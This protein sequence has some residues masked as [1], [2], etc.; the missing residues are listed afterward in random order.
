MQ[1]FNSHIYGN[2]LGVKI[3][4]KINI[5]NLFLLYLINKNDLTIIGQK[6]SFNIMFFLNLKQ[7]MLN[8]IQSRL[9]PNTWSIASSYENLLSD[10]Y[11]L[12]YI[13][14]EKYSSELDTTCGTLVKFSWFV[15]FLYQIC[16][17]NIYSKIYRQ[18]VQTHCT[19]INDRFLYIV[20]I[21]NLYF[22]VFT[23]YFFVPDLY[24]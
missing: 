1:N 13:L 21:Y 23:L 20:C 9:V 22:C 2:G 17:S 18:S 12:F 11:Y 3:Y 14:F 10:F 16:T 8:K 5:K 7:Y 6:L 24:K 15:L 19:L 4:Q